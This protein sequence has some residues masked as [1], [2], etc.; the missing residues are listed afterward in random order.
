[1]NFLSIK[2]KADPKSNWTL[3]ASTLDHAEGGRLNGFFDTSAGFTYAD[4]ACTWAR[5]L[6]EK[7]GVKFVLGHEVGKLEELIVE[8]QGGKKK[9]KGLKT[10]D[11]KKHLADVVVIAGTFVVKGPYRSGRRTE[12][13]LRRRMDAGNHP[14]GCWQAGGYRGK[15]HYYSAAER[16]TG[17]VGP[18]L[19]GEIPCVGVWSDGAQFARVWRVS[20]ACGV[21]KLLKV[22]F[23]GFPRT[24]DGKL[25]LGCESNLCF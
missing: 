23:Y 13:D 18:F 21:K 20:A 12:A 1:M 14:R 17:S 19:A 16:P 6:A 2:E 11:G 5:H 10:A 24:K 8:Q 22:R 15:R 4:K 25:K 7:A 9:V 3:K